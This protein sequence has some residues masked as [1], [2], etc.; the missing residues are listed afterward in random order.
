M[1]GFQ[2]RKAH[3]MDKE[4]LREAAE[5]LAKELESTHGVRARWEGDSV[6]IKGAGVDCKLTHGDDDLL[7]SVQLGLMAMPFK[8]A[9]RS[10]VERFLDQ[11]VA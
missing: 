8:G 1:S 10:E 7:V 4:E 6:R 5:G 2:I 9:L 3:T 11:Y